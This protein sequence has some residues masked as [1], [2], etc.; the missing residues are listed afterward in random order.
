VRKAR[1]VA[2][3]GNGW[4]GEGVH[5]G[6]ETGISNVCAANSSEQEV[7]MRFAITVCLIV[8]AQSLARGH[9]YQQTSKPKANAEMAWSTICEAS[10]FVGDEI[11][12]QHRVTSAAP[13][14]L[15]LAERRVRAEIVIG[16]DTGSTVREFALSQEEFSAATEDRVAGQML[17]R[18][19]SSLGK[20]PAGRYKVA[21]RVRAAP[22]LI[23]GKPSADDGWLSS[24]E[25]EFDVIPFDVR[26]LEPSPLA[27][28][29]L[30]NIALRKTK[31]GRA[32]EAILVNDTDREISF[33]GYTNG[34]R[35][36]ETEAAP[37]P[38][39]ANSA[40]LR[41]GGTA[42]FQPMGICGTG[43][44]D[45]TLSAHSRRPV[46]L[47][48]TPKDGTFLYRLCYRYDKQD[49]GCAYSRACWIDGDRL[50]EFK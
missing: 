8:C 36:D 45:S 20:L 48:V 35:F 6:E 28:V 7:L 18:L 15:S 13:G 42:R 31:H 46:S 19:T 30:E 11:V 14:L 23:G 10:Y 43:L 44:G 38:A 50:E 12:L 22:L 2:Q 1:K 47:Y 17:F 37:A 3:A 29:R 21:L 34:Q 40:L 9:E 41:P 24:P 4:Q 49:V 27:D 32:L 16:K 33:E 5:F 39:L 26:T 25:M